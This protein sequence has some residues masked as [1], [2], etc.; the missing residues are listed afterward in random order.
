MPL[1]SLSPATGGRSIG[2]AALAPADIIVS[3]TN[4]GI[5]RAIRSV[6]GSVVSHAMI[7]AGNDQVIE[8]VGDG[9]RKRS[10]SAALTGASLAVA[11]RHIHMTPTAASAVISFADSQV[12]RGYDFLGIVGQAG[13]QLD[14]WFLCRVQHVRDCEQ[15]AQRANLWMSRDGRFFCSELVAE[16][17]RRAG[18]P[19]VAARSDSVSPQTIVE[20]SISGLLSYVGHIIG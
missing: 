17:Y 15:A 1:P 7:Y 4:A 5:S 11:F 16:S 18:T 10:L 13:Y 6:S 12:R 9:V 3:T 14:R 2:Q 19:L 8:A 20:V